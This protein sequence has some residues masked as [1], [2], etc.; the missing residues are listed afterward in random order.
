MAKAKN[1]AFYIDNIGYKKCLNC[2]NEKILSNFSWVKRQNG[3]RGRCKECEAKIAK[4]SYNKNKKSNRKIRDF[5]FINGEKTLSCFTCKKNMLTK[6][7]YKMLASKTRFTYKCK[8]CCKIYTQWWRY[9][10]RINALR[11]T[12]VKDESNTKI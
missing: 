5:I 2:L 10:N 7:F 6:E 3:Y 1:P 11:R 8:S 4:E 9:N 12:E